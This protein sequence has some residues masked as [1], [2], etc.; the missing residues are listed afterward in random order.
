MRRARRCPTRF[1]FTD[2]R[3]GE[4]LWPALARLPP[5]SGVVFRDHDA[6]DRKA[7]AAR[8]ATLARRRRL[9]L[10]VSGAPCGVRG[11]GTHRAERAVRR[12]WPP[13]LRTAAAHSR[14]A[15]VKA[16]RAGADLVFVSPV[17]ATRSHPG[18]PTLGR[19]RFGLM[20]RAAG[21]PIAALG[22]MTARRFATL[23]PLGAVAWGAIDAFA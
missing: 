17:F 7:R 1:L 6:P 2:A 18:R 21:V 9:V 14:R 16:R 22:G 8:V 12:G 10:V 23:R 13:G 15:V 3:L 19:V 4:A 11:H 20:V 5:G